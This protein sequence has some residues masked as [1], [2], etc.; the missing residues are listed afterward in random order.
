MVKSMARSG[1]AG[2]ST[3]GNPGGVAALVINRLFVGGFFLFS[4]FPRYMDRTGFFNM[5][6][7]ATGKDG[8]YVARNFPLF[9]GLLQN[10]VHPHTQLFGW[11]VIAG[12]TIAGALLLFGLFTRFAACLGMVI[13]CGI[14]LA[15]VNM[16]GDKGAYSLGL[17]GALLAMELAVLL[18]SAGRYYGLDGVLWKRK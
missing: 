7:V 9:A 2:R 6:A 1:S 18:N 16:P 5:L 11:L 17:N 14:L 8:A 15:T 10:V 4:V 12:G 3:R 13:N